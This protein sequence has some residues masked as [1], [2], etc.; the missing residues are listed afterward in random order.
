MDA[1][2]LN[3]SWKRNDNLNDLGIGYMLPMYL[4]SFFGVFQ[5][6]VNVDKS[7]HFVYPQQMFP[8]TEFLC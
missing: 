7:L 1:T 6:Y 3:V 5:T 8:L 4:V 2:I